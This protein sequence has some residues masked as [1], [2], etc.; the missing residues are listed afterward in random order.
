MYV[1]GRDNDVL[2]FFFFF[3]CPAGKL[4][5]RWFSSTALVGKWLNTIVASK[6]VIK[7]ENWTV[8][9]TGKASRGKQEQMRDQTMKSDGKNPKNNK[10]TKIYETLQWSRVLWAGV[11]WWPCVFCFF[12]G[13]S[14]KLLEEGTT[15]EQ[16]WTW[17]NK[18]WNE[19]TCLSHSQRGCI[20]GWVGAEKSAWCA[21]GRLNALL[22]SREC[23]SEG[24]LSKLLLFICKR[25]KKKAEKNHILIKMPGRQ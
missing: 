23:S 11:G 13:M 8:Q 5:N 15:R 1:C 22:S 2:N 21:S 16:K 14:D 20:S 6:L 9:G 3:Y 17:Q 12:F 7:R 10:E 4:D 18:A 24:W 19:R 25:K